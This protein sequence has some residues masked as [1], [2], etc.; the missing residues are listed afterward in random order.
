MDLR[1]SALLATAG[2]AAGVV[3]TIAGAGS[4]LTFPALLGAGLTPLAA[5]VSNCIGVVPGSISGAY[6]LR[7]ALR[8]LGR[9]LAR[10]AAWG[11]AG[12]LVGAALLLNLPSTAFDRV[13]PILVALAGLLVLAQPVI[14]R[15]GKYQTGAERA[16]RFT[17]PVVG[18]IGIYAGYFGAA[19]GVLLIGALGLLTGQP[20]RRTNATKNVIAA[21][22]NGT[23][24][25][26]YALFAPVN[27]VAVLL[28]GLG[29]AAG[30]PIG[31]VLARRIPA[32]PLRVGIAVISLVVAAR[33]AA[34]AW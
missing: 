27:W 15:L 30:G 28:V 31:A 26:V 14:A 24:G 11:A 10:L 33:L 16:S 23:A 9:P 8:G 4:L 12:S 3:N 25:I 20:L 2:W 5:N 32:G 18:L 34:R 7:S 29:S 17:E 1:H 19:I 22:A 6:G 21:A 13:V